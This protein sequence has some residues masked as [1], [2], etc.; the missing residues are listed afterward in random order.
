[1]ENSDIKIK[2]VKVKRYNAMES[3]NSSDKRLDKGKGVDREQ[4]PFHGSEDSVMESNDIP[5]TDKR[6]DKGK[7]VYRE[8]HPFHGSEYNVRPV[9]D[10]VAEQLA[11]NLNPAT[12]TPTE[13]PF[14]L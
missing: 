12:R 6:L 9:I 7:G 8:Q 2:E 3:D 10:N 1:V 11:N 13:P 14:A 4:H 5:D